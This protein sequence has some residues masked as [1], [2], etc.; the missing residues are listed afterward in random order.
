MALGAWAQSVRDD[1]KIAEKN[2]KIAELD[3]Q[4]SSLKSELTDKIREKDITI[5]KLESR[6]NELDKLQKDNLAKAD[7]AA[8]VVKGMERNYRALRGKS[9]FLERFLT[10]R[11]GPS[12]ISKKLFVDHVCAL[13]KQSA[14]YNIHLY[15]FKLE[16]NQNQNSVWVVS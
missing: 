13:W 4:V 2:R 5:A 1:D 10:Y 12:D 14:E 8:D 16:L 7:S 6:V 15:D 3:S 11:N 9:E